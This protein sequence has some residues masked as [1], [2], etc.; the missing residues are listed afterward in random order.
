MNK[1]ILHIAMGVWGLCSI[2]SAFALG[3]SEQ[4]IFSGG[5]KGGIAIARRGIGSLGNIPPHGVDSPPPGQLVVRVAQRQEARR[6]T[7]R[8]FLRPRTHVARRPCRLSSAL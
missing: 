6:G 3:F 7:S 4:F 2:I 1:F 5:V 8:F